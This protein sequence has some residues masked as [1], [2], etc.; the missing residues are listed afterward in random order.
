MGFR[1]VALFKLKPTTTDEQR[2]ALIDH[3]RGLATEIG[4]VR[5]L[6]VGADAQLADDNY[7]CVL[8]ADFDDEP[9]YLVYRDHPLHVS[10]IEQY[11]RPVMAA[12][13]A[14]QYTLIP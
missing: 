7:E 1:H 6:S 3:L 5:S 4:S 13:A 14:I 8:V 9:G 10:V 12:R 11:V 2:Q